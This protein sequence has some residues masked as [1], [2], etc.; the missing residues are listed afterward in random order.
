MPRK[1]VQGATGG[2]S[3]TQ[4]TVNLGPQDMQLVERYKQREFIKENAPAIYKLAMER[5]REIFSE[6]S[7]V[8]DASARPAAQG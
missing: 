3:V 5:L 7:R 4:I 1:K 8:V 2:K 6:R